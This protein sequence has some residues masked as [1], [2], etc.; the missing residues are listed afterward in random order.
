MSVVRLGT[1]RVE[2]PWGRRV[3]GSGFPDAT[4]T[5]GPV[6]EIWFGTP[7]DASD[8]LL[9]KYLFTSERLSVQVHPN[10]RQARA[11]GLPRGKDECWLILEADPDACIAL[12]PRHAIAPDRLVEAIADRSIENLLRW[13][14]VRR[15]DFLFVPAGTVHAIGGGISLIEVQQNSDATYRLYDYGRPRELHVEAGIA[16]ASRRPFERIDG[17]GEVAPGRMILVEGP[18]FVLERWAGN[19]A[20]IAVEPD[21]PGFLVP[22]SGAGEINAQPWASGECFR[23]EG[24]ARIQASEPADLLFAY[25]GRER[26]DTVA[27][28][29]S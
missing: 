15:G 29:G 19:I 26:L 7:G 12:G 25:P 21:Q 14:L 4:G 13:E 22:L 27:M 11:A 16:V 3:L 28:I 24:A 5:E 10:D 9:V 20:E 2:K 6:G 18:T 8:E 23:V 1:H 17:P